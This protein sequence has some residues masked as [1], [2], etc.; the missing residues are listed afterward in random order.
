MHAL[1]QVFLRVSQRRGRAAAA[2]DIL[3]NQKK[4]HSH[5]TESQQAPKYDDTSLV[6]AGQQRAVLSF[7]Q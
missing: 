3:R 5:K 6:Q 2:G 4:R 1:L 7:H